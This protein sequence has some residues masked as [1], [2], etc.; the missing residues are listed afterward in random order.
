MLTLYPDT[1]IQKDELIVWMFGEEDNLIAQ[2]TVR[3]RET[4]DG[5]DG[6]F[7]DRLKL[8]ENTG[9]LTIRNIKSE[10]AG[11]Y[12]LQISSGSRR[13]KYK[14][15]KVITWFHGKQCE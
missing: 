12:K 14:K 2:M 5:A 8:D 9:S 1:E 10:H 3:S 7:R 13:T 4:F 6:R 11:H 15:F